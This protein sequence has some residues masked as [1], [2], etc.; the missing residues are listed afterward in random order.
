MWRSPSGSVESASDSTRL[1]PGCLKTSAVSTPEWEQP[2]E[3][4]EILHRGQI[5]ELLFV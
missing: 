2:K 3:E 5:S 1:V 4:E